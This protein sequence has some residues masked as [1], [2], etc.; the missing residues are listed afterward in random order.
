MNTTIWEK[1]TSVDRI[2]LS[3]VISTVC[4]L[5]AAYIVVKL[6]DIMLKRW[7]KIIVKKLKDSCA[8]SW[9]CSIAL[10]QS[11]CQGFSTISGSNRISFNVAHSK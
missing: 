8:F 1:F 10:D 11:Q 9:V 7:Q 3:K 6:L 5:I 4:I 2:I